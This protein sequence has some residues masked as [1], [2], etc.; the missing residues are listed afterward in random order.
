MGRK[1]IYITNEEIKEANR[2]KA[3]KYYQKHKE[4]IR[5]KR[6]QH[7]WEVEKLNKK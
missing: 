7:Y 2:Q 5:E 4:K 3:S 6:M 1:K